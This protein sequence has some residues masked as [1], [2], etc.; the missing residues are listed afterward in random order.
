M[1]DLKKQNQQLLQELYNTRREADTLKGIIN[2]SP[3][4]VFS[5]DA[6]SN[7]PVEYVSD[8]ISHFGYQPTDFY[9]NRVKLI[10]L[11]HPED[12][13]QLLRNIVHFNKTTSSN[14]RFE[15]RILHLDETISWINIHLYVIRDEYGKIQRLH[16][17]SLDISDQKKAE[18]SKYASKRILR[19]VIDNVPQL[20]CWKDLDSK[21]LGCNK[22]FAQSNGVDNPKDMIGKTDHDFR[23]STADI[24]FIE[25]LEKKVIDSE[26]PLRDFIYEDTRQTKE[27]AIFKQNKQPLYDESGNVMGIIGTAENI[28]SRILTDIALSESEA[29]YRHLFNSANDA[30]F[31]HSFNEEKLEITLVDVN[32][33]A[34][35][36]Y[37]YTKAELLQLEPYGLDCPEAAQSF[38]HKDFL[39]NLGDKNVFETIHITKDGRTVP[40]EISVTVFLLQNQKYLSSIVRDITNRKKIAK[41]LREH[42]TQLEKLVDKRTQELTKAKEQTEKI[43][44]AMEE[45]ST[46]L[47][48][49]IDNIPALIFV[50]DTKSLYTSAN[51][52]CVDFLGESSPDKVLNKNDFYYFPEEVARK[53]Y[54]A[55]QSIFNCETSLL[56][57]EEY[58]PDSDG[59]WCWLHL[60]KIPLTDNRGRIT[61]LIGV[62]HDITHRKQSE[63]ERDKLIKSSEAANRAKS[64]FLANMSH[65]IR[66]PMNGVI[67]M[68][69]LLRNT[70][71]NETQQHYVDML[72][73]SGEFLLAIIN[74]ILDFSKIEARK[75]ELE[76][77]DFDL[78]ELLDKILGIMSIKAQDKNIDFICT[79]EPNVPTLLRGDPDRLQQILLNLVTNGIKFTSDG[80][81]VVR[82]AN[83]REDSKHILLEF[84]IEDTGIGI[85]DDKKSTLFRSFEQ[86][87]SSTTRKFGG[88]GLGLAISKQLCELMGGNITVHTGRKKGTEFHF[89]VQLEKQ[90]DPNSVYL[91]SPDLRGTKILIVDSH[92]IR[93]TAIA[94]QLAG[95][96]G[97][98]THINAF[99]VP[100]RQ[101]P[102][103]EVQQSCYDLALIDEH[104][105]RSG[106]VNLDELV[107]TQGCT[108]NKNMNSVLLLTKGTSNKAGIEGYKHKTLLSNPLKFKDLADSIRDI[109]SPQPVAD[110]SGQMSVKHNYYRSESIL[111]AEDNPINQQVVLGILESMGFLDIEVANNGEEAI[112]SLRNR[113]FDLILMDISMPVMDGFEATTTIRKTRFIHNP[114]TIPIVALTAHA[115]KGD[116]EKCLQAGMDDYLAKPISASDLAKTLSTLLHDPLLTIHTEPTE[117]EHLDHTSDELSAFNFDTLVQRLMGDRELAATVLKLFI[118]DGPTHLAR[119]KSFLNDDNFLEIER[120]A[121][122]IKGAAASVEAKQVEQVAFLLERQC[123][124]GETQAITHTIDMLSE[125]ITTATVLMKVFI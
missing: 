54:T 22:A 124:S 15:C 101:T 23:Y 87:D 31:L 57:Q 118:Q 93:R 64:T 16:G 105:V 21:Y 49:V 39:K 14:L 99:T 69:S 6:T 29:R 66:T 58:L 70:K 121:H 42:Q 47:R 109:I 73:K 94:E 27:R 116:R 78:H 65:E 125:E 18:L 36:R 62:G 104:L 34:C 1:T 95:W 96:G 71:L 50:K 35:K 19:T 11:V 38:N 75:L 98:I 13:V 84:L 107:K 46:F 79:I 25:D 20:I 110:E 44:R 17:T 37:G 8:N 10:S 108:N 12:K 117:Q 43:N 30:I 103:S 63:K 55:E 89:S 33:I 92:D 48:S 53:L 32:N 9:S 88:T 100:N 113:P 56:D 68:A 72:Q 51:K 122:K 83:K 120:L 119:L 90:T 114:S 76:S 74:D 67:G 82:V 123:N 102:T 4:V 40:V 61:G 45:Q 91:K 3:V 112:R 86:L 24:S 5:W 111:L 28:T 81:V 115:I 52:T 77:L 26:I 85:P 2:K 80:E 97:A 7:Q 41:D 106:N 59:N 60:T